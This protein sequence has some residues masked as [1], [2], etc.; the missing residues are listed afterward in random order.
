[1]RKTILICICAGLALTT[2]AVTMGYLH[3]APG[4]VNVACG[5]VIGHL[6]FRCGRQ[7]EAIARMQ[8]RLDRL[9]SH[10]MEL[11]GL[12]S[13][14]QAP[15]DQSDVRWERLAADLG[16]TPRN[17]VPAPST[18][19]PLAELSAV[20]VTELTA[21]T[22]EMIERW[23]TGGLI[24]ALERNSM[25]IALG[26]FTTRQSEFE[27]VRGRIR[28]ILE[29]ARDRRRA[30]TGSPSDRLNTALEVVRDVVM[31]QV[32][33]AA[34]GWRPQPPVFDLREL[35]EINA[36]LR[37]PRGF[38]GDDVDQWH[39]PGTRSTITAWRQSGRITERIYD[40]MWEIYESL[41][42]GRINTSIAE[43]NLKALLEMNDMSPVPPAA[44]RQRE[45]LV[46]L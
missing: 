24:D 18:V 45:R 8:A 36:G 16:A 6:I 33:D 2:V 3:G 37:G 13:V 5:A 39:Y 46:Q 30:P 10:E 22:N 26:L 28:T 19:P 25:R 21:S 31:Q 9:A 32:R 17:V 43:W 34:T 35:Q 15:A 38:S 4:V 23:F 1:M 14:Q 11:D 40:Q 12:G 42:A 27:E 44:S 7:R 41:E 29:S 20:A